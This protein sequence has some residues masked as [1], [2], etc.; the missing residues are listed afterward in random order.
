MDNTK[1][2]K[3]AWLSSLS[4]LDDPTINTSIVVILLLYSSQIFSNINMF[5]G[6]FY[7]FSIVRLIV[8]LL[9]I[10]VAPK[11]TT[12]AILLTIS[13]LVSLHFMMYNENFV[14][15]KPSEEQINTIKNKMMNKM[16]G[17]MK[18]ISEEDMMGKMKNISEED[19]MGK[20][21]SKMKEH[22]FPMQTQDN[23]EPSFNPTMPQKNMKK[24][25]KQQQQQ[26]ESECMQLYT[27]RFEQLSN[28][29]EPTSTFKG[30]LNAQGLN[31]PEG[32]DS[33]VMGSPLS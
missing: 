3:K 25:N 20:S 18:N 7:R 17:K 22:F 29:C 32:F 21:G 14:S 19:M 6:N 8:L 13:Y 12:I 5:M 2:L 23:V 10:Y 26:P 15:S 4:F 28:V 31:Y 30:E 24:I 11:D 1:N 33:T 16:M 27:P 9:I